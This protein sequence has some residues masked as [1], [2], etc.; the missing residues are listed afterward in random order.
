MDKIKGQ[1]AKVGELV[2]AS[3]TGAA[4]QKTLGL[5]WNILRETAILLW[6]VVCLLFVGVEWFWQT[7]TTLGKKAR[8]W[9]E[10]LSQPS[11]QEEKSFGE[12]GQSLW[13]TVQSGAAVLLYQAKQQLGIDA[14][15]PAPPA[16][17]PT[18]PP[19]PEPPPSAVAPSVPAPPSVSAPEVDE[20][21][22][23]EVDS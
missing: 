4:Y 1:A 18:P 6:L 22:E 12:I 15:P 3:E 17:K 13:D 7:A 14:E 10:T 5:T 21:D 9:Y 20:V 2:F 8:S 23:T 19:A 16:P 11:P